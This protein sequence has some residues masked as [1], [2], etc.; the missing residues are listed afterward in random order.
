MTDRTETG[1]VDGVPYKLQRAR[2][3]DVLHV[4]LRTRV[5]HVWLEGEYFGNLPT[6]REAFHWMRSILAQRQA[7]A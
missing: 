1:C 5:W 3:C 4:D 2:L 6:K 7:A